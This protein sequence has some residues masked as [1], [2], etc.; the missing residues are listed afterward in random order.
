MSA[1]EHVTEVRALG[2]RRVLNMAIECEDEHGYARSFARY[3]KIPM[4]DTVEEENV[5]NGV[6]EAC[7]F[8][9]EFRQCNSTA[10]SAFSPFV[11]PFE[12]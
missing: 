8:L 12:R 6:R 1:P 7:Q 2:V 3:Y 11:C 4:R 10:Y 9:G 5:K